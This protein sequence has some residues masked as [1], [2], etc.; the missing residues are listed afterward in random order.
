MET[1]FPDENDKKDDPQ[2]QRPPFMDLIRLVLYHFRIANAHIHDFRIANSE[3][4]GISPAYP[5][6]PMAWPIL[7]IPDTI[8]DSHHTATPRVENTTSYLPHTKRSAVWGP[9]NR[10][11]PCNQKHQHPDYQ[12]QFIVKVCNRPFACKKAQF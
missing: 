11:K 7:Y 5:P 10:K 8:H 12:H 4:R 9:N 1:R 3:E 6:K 2:K